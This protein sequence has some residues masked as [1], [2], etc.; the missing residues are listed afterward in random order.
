MVSL[1]RC[2]CQLVN[3]GLSTFRDV[4]LSNLCSA[5]VCGSMRVP[6]SDEHPGANA[7]SVGAIS[8]FASEESGI[9][10]VVHVHKDRGSPG[11]KNDPLNSGPFRIA[12]QALPAFILLRVGLN[13]P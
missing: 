9:L 4:K 13:S 11:P 2:R 12:Q 7:K 5:G 10:L 6:S 1:C 3:L 8:C